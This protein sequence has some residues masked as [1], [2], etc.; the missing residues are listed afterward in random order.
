MKRKKYRNW[1]PEAQGRRQGEDRTRVLRLLRSVVDRAQAEFDRN[2]A[3]PAVP[4]SQALAA[5]RQLERIG[6]MGDDERETP[7]AEPRR[8]PLPMGENAIITMKLEPTQVPAGLL[9]PEPIRVAVRPP[10]G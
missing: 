5:A 1:K 9:R 6:D 3:K 8:E 4:L 7:A 2:E 10:T